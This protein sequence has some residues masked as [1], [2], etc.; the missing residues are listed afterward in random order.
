[1]RSARRFRDGFA[2]YSALVMLGA[3]W[4]GA[5]VL[6]FFGVS[7]SALRIA[8]GLVVASRAWSLLEAPE[9]NEVRSRNR[10]R[11]REVR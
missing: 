8:G 2:V 3:L 9:E 11:S 5:Y 7:L 10:P 1:M 6:N 4:G